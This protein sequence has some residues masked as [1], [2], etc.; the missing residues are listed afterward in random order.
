ME[1]FKNENLGIVDT[2]ND[3][4]TVLKSDEEIV[5]YL[6]SNEKFLRLLCCPVWTSEIDNPFEKLE[7]WA[8]LLSTLNLKTELKLCVEDCSFLKSSNLQRLIDIKPF[9]AGLTWNNTNALSGGCFDG[10]GLTSFGKEVLKELEKNNII[11]DTAHANRQ[12]FFDIA[13]FSSKPL[14]C[15][16]TAVSEILS[17]PRNLS[18]DQISEIVNSGGY[19]GIY[20]VGNFLSNRPSTSL[21]VARQFDYIISRYGDSC[22]GL[23]TDFN[24]TTNLPSDLEGYGD[25]ENVFNHLINF[26]YTRETI[27]KIQFRN[28]YE[29]YGKFMK[30]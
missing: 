21:D 14:F 25:I 4:L 9:Y 28:F 15:S 11:I 7:H 27:E 2:H 20:F 5:S 3:L 29:F 18:D 22:V 12:S 16:H 30:A 24:G 1:I 17:T 10:G 8:R 19:I 13:N 6:K 26:G 23:G